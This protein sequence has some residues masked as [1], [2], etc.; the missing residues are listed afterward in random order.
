MSDLELLDLQEAKTIRPRT[1]G[2]ILKRNRHGFLALRL[3]WN[4]MRSWEGTGLADTPENRTL[5]EAAALVISSEIKKK[6]FDYLRHFPKGNKAHLFR[7]AT[8]P[9]E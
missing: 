8:E 7:P 9:T 2:C 4:G 6:T 3:F 5:L 1:V